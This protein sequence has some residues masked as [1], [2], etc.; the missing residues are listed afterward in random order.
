MRTS[1]VILQHGTI[2]LDGDIA[3]I[4]R[5]LTDPP[6]PARVRARAATLESAL[7]RAVTWT[8]TVDAMIV[9]FSTALNVT[10]SRKELT[11]EE[12]DWMN[13]LRILKYADDAWTWR[14]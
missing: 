8:E 2:P 13:E 1:E 3:R 14:L 7:G 11:A 10:L 5:Y 12:Q 4:C 6:D 9:G